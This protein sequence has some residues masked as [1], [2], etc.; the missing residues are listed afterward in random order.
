[1][2]EAEAILGA[3][4]YLDVSLEELARRLGLKGRPLLPLVLGHH[5]A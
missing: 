3:E 1:M 2:N 4:G 5:A